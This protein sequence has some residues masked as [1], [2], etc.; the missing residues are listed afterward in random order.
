[1]ERKSMESPRNR[2]GKAHVESG[3]KVQPGNKGPQV[4]ETKTVGIRLLKRARYDSEFM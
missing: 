4:A 3:A 2:V 1:M